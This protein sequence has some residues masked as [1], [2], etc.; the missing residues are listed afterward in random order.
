MHD[1]QDR[2]E[3]LDADHFG[4]CKFSGKEDAKYAKVGPEVEEIY[5]RVAKSIMSSTPDVLGVL[6]D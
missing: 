2:R 6:A 1:N 3:R 4:M 5:T